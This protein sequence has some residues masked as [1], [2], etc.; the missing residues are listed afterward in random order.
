MLS[1]ADSPRKKEYLLLPFDDIWEG[2]SFK[3]S[4]IKEI[5]HLTNGISIN[6]FIK[7]LE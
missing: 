6:N 4:H 5:T 1:I 2:Y 3:A 7:S